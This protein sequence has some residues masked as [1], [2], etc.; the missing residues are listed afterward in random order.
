MR[1]DFH[2]HF[3]FEPYFEYLDEYGEKYGLRYERDEQGRTFFYYRGFDFGPIGEPLL[4]P[5]SRLGKMDRAGLDAQ[6]LTFGGPGI[7]FMD[8]DDGVAMARRINDYL[9]GVQRDYPGRLAGLASVPL[10][11]VDAACEELTRAVKECALLGVGIFSNVNGVSLAE[12]RF[13][14]FFRRAAELDVPIFIHPNLPAANP[15]MTRYHLGALVGYMFE[16]TLLFTTLV[17]NGLFEQL[18]TLKVVFPHLGGA[19]PFLAERL[20]RGYHY[21]EVRNNL[22]APPMESFRRAYVDTVSFYDPAMRCAHALFGADHMVLGSDYPFGIGD[23]TGA[24]KSVGNLGLSEAEQQAILG[25]TAQ[26]L[27]GLS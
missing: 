5:Q 4:N 16:T 2:S 3:W 9:A 24:M 18:P 22:K 27:L 26:K 19:L 21:A 1:I 6:V 10:R 25:G 7:S 14:P 20:N 11:D 17:Y 23:L 15:M 12:E 8:L 13:V